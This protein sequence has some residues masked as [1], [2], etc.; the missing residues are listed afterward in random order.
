M[1]RKH[2]LVLCLCLV[3]G[4]GIAVYVWATGCCPE[5]HVLCDAFASKVGDTGCDY[6]FGVNLARDCAGSATVKLWYHETPGGSWN[7]AMMAI[8]DD[9]PYP[10]C[11]RM[12]RTLTL[13]GD[14]TYGYYFE[15]TGTNCNERLPAYP[16]E[17]SLDPNCN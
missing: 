16:L 12:R 6:T 4:A 5:G 13:D 7:W 10:P 9:W 2:L 8:I 15:S 11:V 1:S 14:K 17:Y 3:I